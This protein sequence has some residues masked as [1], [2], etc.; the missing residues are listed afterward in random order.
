MK[1]SFIIATMVLLLLTSGCT[2]QKQQ[3][4]NIDPKMNVLF[5]LIDDLGWKDTG[6][7]GSKYYET[8]HL[9]ALSKEGMVF[10]NAYA[11]A[12]NCAPSRACLLSGLN[13]PRHQV[14]TVSP[15]DRGNPR[16]RKI[17]PTPNIKFLH[18]SVYTL[19]EM[20]KSAGYVTGSFGKWHIGQEP[21]RQGVDVNIAGGPNGSPGKNGYFSPYNVPN[22]TDGPEGEYL[23]DRLTDEV[24]S[25]LEANKDTSFFAYVPYYTVHTPLLAREDWL[26]KYENKPGI[27]GQ[28][29]PVYGAMVSAMDENIG[30]LLNKLKGLG[31]DENTIVIFTS[32]NGG[33]RFISHQDPL[34]AGKGS[35][36][37]GGVRVPLI[38][39]WPGMT[40]PGTR[41]DERTLNMDFFPTLQAMAQ[42]EIKATFLDGIDITPVFS[43]Q[44]LE[45]RDLFWHFPIYPQAYKRGQ[46]G[47]RDSLFRTRPGSIIISGDWK[48]HEYFEDGGLELYD[49]KNDPGESDNLAMTQPEKTRELHDR[50]KKW[51]KHTNAPVPGEPN[52]LYD[53]DY[54]ESAFPFF[55]YRHK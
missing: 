27:D 41:S 3:Q 32:D 34:R 8:P 48:M 29:H 37:E 4:D 19:H 18:D 30:R 47:S 52:P 23:P 13:T 12:A 24:I 55:Q 42:P 17:I 11:G 46:D 54:T 6:F 45:D 26:K 51:R 50:L 10:V 36:Y 43:G 49:L 22:I 9:D 7:M 53:P 35:Y 39:K 25:F 31:L 14:Y 16:T 1:H 20:F 21:T 44:Q 40:T 5:I 28:A 38:I 15:S 33:I 2:D